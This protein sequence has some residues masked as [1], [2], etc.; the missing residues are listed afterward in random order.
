MC[1]ILIIVFLVIWL[2]SFY[3]DRPSVQNRITGA[4]AA[5]HSFLEAAEVRVLVVV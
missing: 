2:P 4:A 3:F 1:G 5:A